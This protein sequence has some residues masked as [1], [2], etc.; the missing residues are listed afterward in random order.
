MAR[1][2]TTRMSLFGVHELDAQR[3]GFKLPLPFTFFFFL[4]RFANVNNPLPKTQAFVAK[5]SG[6]T[7]L[8]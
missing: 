2:R 8:L 3:A 4:H 7:F 6:K 5:G 1:V